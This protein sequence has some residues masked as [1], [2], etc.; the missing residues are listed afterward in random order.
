MQL[1]DA[2]LFI[3]ELAYEQFKARAGFLSIAMRNLKARN[4]HCQW[5]PRIKL[6]TLLN[7]VSGCQP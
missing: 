7:E 1:A 4:N 6:I 5:N 2:I 3:N